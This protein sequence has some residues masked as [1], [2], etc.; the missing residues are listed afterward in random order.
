LKQI[1][2]PKKTPKDIKEWNHRMASEA[3]CGTVVSGACVIVD[4]ETKQPLIVVGEV[5][6]E[7]TR[8]LFAEL[9]Q[10]KF[11]VNHRSSGMAGK[12]LTFG[13]QPREPFKRRPFCSK[14]SLSKTAPALQSQLV[15]T[16]ETL[17]AYYAE[18]SPEKHHNQME[19]ISKEILPDWRM[20]NTPFTSGIINQDNVLTYHLDRGNFE[21]VWSCMIVM[22]RDIF[23]GDL[24]VPEYDLL[25]KLPDRALVMFD[26]QAL[27][28]GVT[29]FK[30]AHEQSRRYSI[31]FYSLKD[32]C[33]CGTPAEELK[34]GQKAVQEAL[35][36]R[37]ALRKK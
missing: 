1:L 23:G 27:I 19:K 33:K 12:S 29:P 34:H 4:P 18:A 15:R 3:D 9:E 36:K 16:G 32:M 21:G 25:I 7:I 11:I 13:Y 20:G 28:H 26:G 6:N 22:K 2:A 14:T 31:V 24:C 17:S 35:E 30:K 8:P 5:S 10:L 37:I